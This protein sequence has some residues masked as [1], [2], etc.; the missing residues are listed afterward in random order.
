MQECYVLFESVSQIR[1]FVSIA[2]KQKFEIR[3]EQDNM[4]TSATSIMS[5]FSMGLH[6]PIRVVVPNA[7]VDT[8]PFF[9]AVQSYAAT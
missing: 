3:L 8:A 4:S 2:T 7:Q 1:D 5:I 6:R 9:Q